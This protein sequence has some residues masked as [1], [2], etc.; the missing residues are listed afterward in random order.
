MIHVGVH[1]RFHGS[2]RLLT[3]KN[4]LPSV[5]VVVQSFGSREKFKILKWGVGMERGG[6]VILTFK[7]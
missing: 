5:M 6:T 3:Q 4:I 7:I 2:R 1:E